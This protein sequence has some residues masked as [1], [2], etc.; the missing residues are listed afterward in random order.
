MEEDNI[1]YIAFSIL[2]GKYEWLVMSFGLKNAPQIFQRKMDNIFKK[3]SNFLI[4]Y[5]DDILICSNNKK[6]HKNHLLQFI[7][8]CKNE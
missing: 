8:E 2:Q 4:V 1:Q 7:N 5:I 3:F 6:E